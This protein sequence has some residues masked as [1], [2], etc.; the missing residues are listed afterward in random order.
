MQVL[1]WK[2]D[3]FQVS[4]FL[5]NIVLRYAKKIFYGSFFLSR[6]SVHFVIDYR[7]RP[8]AESEFWWFWEFL[9]ILFCYPK[10][11]SYL[12]YLRFAPNDL[13]QRRLCIPQ[14]NS[15]TSHSALG[16]QWLIPLHLIRGRP[17]PLLSP[18]EHSSLGTPYENIANKFG[19]SKNSS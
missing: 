4:R 3:F 12:S 2:N 15:G 14:G 19:Y 17:R 16:S 5:R 11:S 1:F 7:L 18:F 13:L 9:F 8:G 10:N 6:P